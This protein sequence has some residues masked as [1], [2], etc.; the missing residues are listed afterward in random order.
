MDRIRVAVLGATGIVGQR[1]VEM[2]SK[3]PWFSIEYLSSSPQNQGKRYGD[4]V[5]WVISDAVPREA[6]GIVMG[7]GEPED[8]PRDIDVVFSALPSSVALDVELGLVRR[9][10]TVIS[11]TSP[12]RLDPDVPLLNPEVNHGHLKA[13]ELQGVRRGWRGALLKDP[14]CTTAI[15]TLSLAPLHREFGVES[16]TV[17]SMQAISGAGLRGL[18]AYA[19]VDNVIPYIEREE[20][21][22]VNETRKILGEAR[23][24]GIEPADIGVFAT[25][26][27]VPV[28]DAHLEVVYVELRKG[29]EPEDAANAMKSFRSL[30]Q[31]LHLPTAPENPIVVRSEV[32]RPQP[33][34]DRYVGK[35]MSVTVGRIESMGSRRIR[36]VVLGHNT[37]RGAAGNAILIAELY[38]KHH[39]GV[40]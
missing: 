3:H 34:L 35:G 16:V 1:F 11:N 27:R 28:L 13:L 29:A 21:K 38:L 19:I 30:P 14:N 31:E 33:R 40:V 17:V 6:A 8:L 9:G 18:P 2:L 7:S 26:T 10:F 37:I 32:D 20:W 39:L 23:S 25:A 4:V 36:Y 24:S 22:V 15:L 12:M 5:E